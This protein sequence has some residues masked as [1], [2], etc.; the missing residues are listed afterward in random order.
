MISSFFSK[1]TL[2]L[3]FVILSLGGCNSPQ[4]PGSEFGETPLA[5]SQ[6]P[7]TV[8]QEEEIDA[9]IIPDI[10]EPLKN[11]VFG[12]VVL[13]V[14]SK[15]LL[16][17]NFKVPAAW[18]DDEIL[19]KMY[20]CSSSKAGV[21]YQKLFTMLYVPSLK[22]WRLVNFEVQTRDLN[23]K[24][25]SASRLNKGA[26]AYSW[27]AQIRLNQDDKKDYWMEDLEL[28]LSSPRLTYNKGSRQVVRYHRDARRE[29]GL[30]IDIRAALAQDE[31]DTLSAICPAP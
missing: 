22:T 24:W 13:S 1:S 12:F 6:N 15:S 27:Q 18:Q 3:S 5:D 20:V 8:E 21:N 23:W 2:F 16:E 9:P 29:T 10:P 30:A 31:K 26:G 7:E 11:P 28:D 14:K 19:H 17:E 25:D 4:N